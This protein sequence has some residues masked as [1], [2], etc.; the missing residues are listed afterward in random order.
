MK[1]Y[2]QCND[3]NIIIESKTNG[4]ELNQYFSNKISAK[5]LI[6]KFGK[7][8]IATKVEIEYFLKNK[9][10]QSVMADTYNIDVNTLI[11]KVKE[12]LTHY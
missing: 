10:L 2:T 3:N 9:F 5:A 4:S 12:L 7:D 8:K 11:D 6:R 1:N